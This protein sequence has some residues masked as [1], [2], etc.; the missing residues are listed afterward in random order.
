MKNKRILLTGGAGFIGTKI[1][2]RYVNDNK[3]FLY[4]SFRRDSLVYSD[5]LK[6]EN[7]T[8]IHGDVLDANQLKT[9]M[10]DIKPTHIIHLAAIAGI[11]TV[12][13]H[14]VDTL[15][16][17]V[18]GTYNV[19]EAAKE[20][21]DTIERFVDISTSEVFGSYAFKA[22]ESSNTNLAPVGEARWTYSIS[23][24]IGEHFVHAYYKE[25][26]LQTV[27]IR[28]F[29]IYGP[30]QVG[31]GAVHQFVT[32]AI[33]NEGINIHG[34]GDQIRSWCYIDDFVNALC[35]CLENSGAVGNTFNIGNPRATLTIS[36]LAKLIV[37]IAESQST[38]QYVP[39]HY[40]DVELRIPSI[41]KAKE[42][43]GYD[44]QVEL[45]EGLARTIAWYRGLM[46]Q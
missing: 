27:S 36:M 17:N 12:I 39:K 8:I 4:D 34:D 24:L 20:H 9:V 42:R 31:E 3:I 11:D 7:V 22:E 41:E 40:A 15:K 45:D 16:V 13:N 19:L 32:R 2:E 29:N 44:P 21:A 18:I 35:T 10:N 14:P 33:R 37:S 5:K 43:L 1:A 38:I 28:P 25:Y 23:K 30:G 46:N 26:G 6:H